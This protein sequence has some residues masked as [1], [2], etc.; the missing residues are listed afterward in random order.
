MNPFDANVS[1]LEQEI[2]QAQ[3]Q[4]SSLQA[5]YNQVATF[6]AMGAARAQLE[7]AMA[8]VQ[9]RIGNL[10]AQ[11]EVE[12]A[13]RDAVDRIA[14]ER[15]QQGESVE[16]AYKSATKAATANAD[17]IRRIGMYIGIGVAAVLVIVAL[18]FTLRKS[19]K[20]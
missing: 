14:Q 16:D 19:P 13:R 4:L 15:M 9:E 20:A 7:A 8:V 17:A 11:L 2:A 12:R 5:Q 18:W 10:Q 3:A 6:P 1:G